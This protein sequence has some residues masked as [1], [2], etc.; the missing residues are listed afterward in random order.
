MTVTP[1][2]PPA[3]ACLACLLALLVGVSACGRSKEAVPAETQP[4]GES[5][6]PPPPAA[7]PVAAA[8]MAAPAAVQAGGAGGAQAAEQRPPAT[9]TPRRII[10]HANQTVEVPHL[11]PAMESI[12]RAVSEFGGYTTDE[13]HRQ[14]D[15]GTH[16]ASITCRVPADKL[17]QAIARVRELGRQEQLNITAEDISEAYSDLEIQI[18]NQKRLE[19]RLLDLL[20]RQTNRLADLLEI[21]RETARV[22]GEID[23]MEGRKRFWDNQLALSTL[24]VTLHEPRPAIASAGGGPWRTLRD[25]FGEAG[26]NFVLTIAGIISAAGTLVPLAVV[27]II[28]F[29]VLRWMRRRWRAA[30]ARARA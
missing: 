23:Q 7:A 18:T 10:R 24:I 29:V 26:D 13:S 22:R 6:S 19:A 3:I 27:L 2:R 5:I 30:K 11:D 4:A 16:T 20:N 1:R 28:L 17:D 14:D 21:E 8:R 15:N 12:R 25:A 9:A